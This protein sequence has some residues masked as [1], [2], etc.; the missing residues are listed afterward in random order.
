MKKIIFNPMLIYM[1]VLLTSCSHYYYAPNAA[2]IPLFKEKNSVEVK[3]GFSGDSY[4]GADIQAGYS[5]SKKVGVIV[6]SFFAGESESVTNFNSDYSHKE[7]GS[8][9][10]F[11]AGAGYYKPFGKNKTWIFETYGGAGIGGEKHV[12]DYSQSATLHLTKYFIQPSFGYN[13]KK[14]TFQFAVS[15]RFSS[16]NLKIKSANL[17]AESNQREKGKLDQIV[18]HPTSFLWEPS[19]M[20][21]LGG[22]HVKFYFQITT[23]SN[24]N[25]SYLFMDVGNVSLG[26]KFKFDIKPKKSATNNL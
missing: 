11:E 22:E 20:I 12:Y 14:E 3:G 16:L 24:L 4:N 17:S 25:N 1:L 10:Y 18:S 15:C 19:Y 13:S 2:N 9:S 26:A 21:A 5:V 8:G 6:N 7:S 23:S